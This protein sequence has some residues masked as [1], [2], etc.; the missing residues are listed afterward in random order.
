MHRVTALSA[1]L[2]IAFTIRRLATTFLSEQREDFNRELAGLAAI[3][4][5]VHDPAGSTVESA[6]PSLGP[7]MEQRKSEIEAADRD[8]SHRWRFD[9]FFM[10]IALT[11]TC[12]RTIRDY[13][14]RISLNIPDFWLIATR[15][16]IQPRGG[17]QS[18]EDAKAARGPR[19]IHIHASTLHPAFG[20]RVLPG[21][22]ADVARYLLLVPGEEAERDNIEAALTWIVYLGDSPASQG[23]VNLEPVLR[24]TYIRLGAP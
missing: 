17:F 16:D 15:D 22:S 20:G 14:I 7:R 3:L 18:A 9:E 10:S 2:N 4:E 8:L 13:D 19:E 5:R 12:E 6:D 21:M 23:Q 1:E 24:A 11:N